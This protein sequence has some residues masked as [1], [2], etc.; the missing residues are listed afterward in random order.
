MSQ[1]SDSDSGYNGYTGCTDSAAYADAVLAALG[2]LQAAKE[3]E[4][5]TVAN[6]EFYRELQK[7]AHKAGQCISPEQREK[8]GQVR[9]TSTR[10]GTF[11]WC[12]QYL[13]EEARKLHLLLGPG[14]LD[15]GDGDGFR[16]A[17]GPLIEAQVRSRAPHDPPVSFPTS[18]GAPGVHQ[19]L[20]HGVCT[21]EDED[22]EEEEEE[23]EDDSDKDDEEEDE[24]DG[25]GAKKR[26]KRTQTTSTQAKKPAAATPLDQA[27]AN[28]QAHLTDMQSCF[29]SFV[30][31]RR[32]KAECAE[33][34]VRDAVEHLKACTGFAE[35]GG[36]GVY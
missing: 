31:D 2:R 16:S 12:I 36:R 9:V 35:G 27:L 28:F 34:A 18:T 20:P 13:L 22:Y 24:D 33:L 1:D 10:Q 8:N 17:L 6:T 19:L 26:A 29:D 21:F 11:Y 5:A 14:L 15:S 30:R 25:G 23:E 32:I 3:V 4:Q 7:L